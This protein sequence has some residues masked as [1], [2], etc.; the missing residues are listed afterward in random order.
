MISERIIF[1][2]RGITVLYILNHRD[3][4]TYHMLEHRKLLYSLSRHHQNNRYLFFYVILTSFSLSL[5]LCV[6]YGLVI[7]FFNTTSTS[8]CF[9]CLNVRSHIFT[10]RTNSTSSI[11][12]IRRRDIQIAYQSFDLFRRDCFQS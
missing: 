2:S 12:K 7:R 11:F 3:D 1:V 6:L 10:L 8:F 4:Y 9:E 5:R